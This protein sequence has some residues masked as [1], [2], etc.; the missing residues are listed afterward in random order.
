M[1]ET[2][3][4]VP[5]LPPT[6][7]SPKKDNK[8]QILAASFFALAAAILVLVIVLPSS[9]SDSSG[10]ASTNAPA[11]V[12]TAA[13]VNKYDQYYEHVLNNS[14]QANSMAKSKVIEFGDL[15][16]Q[17]LDEGNSV[18]QVVNVVSSAVGS[19]SD[20]ELGAAV[21]FA[22][23]KYICPEYQAMMDAYLSN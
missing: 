11:P 23:V 9:N 14:G 13:P 22:A 21:I 3:N 20:L 8:T 12:I 19:T 10:S 2:N 4:I 6:P 18:A 17:A 7:Q 5:P 1:S 16:C 15:V